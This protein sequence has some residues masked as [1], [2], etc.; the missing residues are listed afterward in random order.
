MCGWV[1][2]KYSGLKSPAAYEKSPNFRCTLC[3]KNT[4][5]KPKNYDPAHHG[6]QK[7]YT[8][9]NDPSA[10]RSKQTLRGAAATKRMIG[11]QVNKFLSLSET[12]TKFRASKN[13]FTRPKVQPYRINEIWSGDL[14]DVHQLAKDNDAKKSFRFS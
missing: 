12:Y 1:H 6:L 13:N 3:L 5:F 8:T 11:E 7:L 2:F 4:R 9:T 10:F 14:A